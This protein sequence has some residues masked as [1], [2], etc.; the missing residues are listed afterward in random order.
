MEPVEFDP[1][2]E[3][4]WPVPF[5]SVRYTASDPLLAMN[6]AVKEVAV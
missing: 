3:S 6:P 5:V 1:V 4:L 2:V